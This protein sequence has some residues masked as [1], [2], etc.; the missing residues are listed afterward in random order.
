M[1]NTVKAVLMSGVVCMALGCS[2]VDNYDVVFLGGGTAAG[3]VSVAWW[4]AYRRR[5]ECD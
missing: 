5:C 2:K 4:H 3:G 1:Q